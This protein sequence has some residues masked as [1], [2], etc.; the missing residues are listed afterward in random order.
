MSATSAVERRSSR[1]INMMQLRAWRPTGASRATAR[2][3]RRGQH[4]CFCYSATFELA[5]WLLQGLKSCTEHLHHYYLPALLFYLLRKCGRSKFRPKQ[6]REC[7]RPRFARKASPA[8]NHSAQRRTRRRL[9]LIATFGFL[10]AATPCTRSRAFPIWRRRS[11]RCR[12]LG[13]L[14]GTSDTMDLCRCFA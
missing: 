12:E 11:N 14:Y 7:L 8:K 2:S 9:D 13:G 1:F 10:N 5:G 6:F 3:T 4:R